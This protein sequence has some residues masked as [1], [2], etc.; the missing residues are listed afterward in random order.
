MKEENMNITVTQ[1]ELNAIR[2]AL[3]ELANR[4]AEQAI[5]LRNRLCAKDAEGLRA[6]ATR[7]SQE[8]KQQREQKTTMKG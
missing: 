3:S 4:R 1:T 7:I 8:G 2:Y 6:L 5:D